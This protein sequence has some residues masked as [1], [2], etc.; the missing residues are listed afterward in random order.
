MQADCDVPRTLRTSE[1][2]TEPGLSPQRLKHRLYYYARD[3]MAITLFALLADKDRSEVKEL[4]GEVRSEHPKDRVVCVWWD[5][6]H[7]LPRYGRTTPHFVGYMLEFMFRRRYLDQREHPLLCTLLLTTSA[8]ISASICSPHTNTSSS[9]V[10]NS[11][12]ETDEV[13]KQ[14]SKTLHSW[15]D[16]LVVI[17]LILIL[18]ISYVIHAFLFASYSTG[19]VFTFL[20]HLGLADFPILNNGNFSEP[21][22]F[23]STKSVTQSLLSLPPLQLSPL[24]VVVLSGVH[25]KTNDLYLEIG[26]SW[27]LTTVPA[28]Q[29]CLPHHATLPCLPCRL[30]HT[31]A[32]SF[33]PHAVHTYVL[34]WCKLLTILQA[35]VD[36]DGQK[37]TPLIIAARQ[38]HDKVV[39]MMLQE[40]KQ[41]IEQEGTVK[42]D[43]YV[44][45]GAS[46][47][48]CAAG[49]GHLN[50]V[51]T[52]VKMGADVNHPTKT[53]STPLRAAC[54]DGRLDIVRYL[55]D[56]LADIH[57]A[58]KYNNT[59]LMIAA[60]KGHLDVVSFLLEKGANPNERA[61]CGATAMHF[62]AECGHTSIVQE[63]LDHG[64]LMT[65]NEHGMTPLIA[66]AERTRAE[67]VEYLITRPE[68]SR[69]E[70][71]DALE[72]L[73]AS[74]ANDKDYY[75]LEQAYNYL[76][77][78]MEM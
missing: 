21:S 66:A 35:V 28:V 44:I 45:E 8:T 6:R 53:N 4:L 12:Y 51:K 26:S 25:L 31:I 9:I 7:G 59:C 75:C 36:E 43:G 54:F 16:L 57:I 2:M 32:K 70:K 67:V 52:L 20:K 27:S 5:V 56:H 22:I 64:A 73:G 74:F 71:I 48:W 46:S 11:S 1:K 63:L 3:G 68:V 61:H 58:N 50:V 14:V 77:R 62:A 23:A 69:E 78:T 47:L 24:K 55:T 10:T 29:K 72:L 15:H 40:F 41:D 42:F 37:C 39:K 49:A 65:K 19:L 18:D 38:G 33:V 34:N 30:L 17:F 13:V 76:H 60:Y